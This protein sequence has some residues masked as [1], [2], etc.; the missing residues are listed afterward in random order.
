VKVVQKGFVLKRIV[1]SETSCILSC[2][3][4]EYGLKSF[5]FKGARKKS[6]HLLQALSPIE[7]TFENRN[8]EQLVNMFQV[9]LFYNGHDIQT[10]ALKMSVLFFQCELLK[11]VLIDGQV[12]EVLF[13]FVL[14]EYKWLNENQFHSNYLIFWL[15]KL[16]EIIGFDAK[17]IKPNELML[18]LNDSLFHEIK[19]LNKN[20]TLSYQIANKDKKTLIEAILK[21]YQLKTPNFS[22][23]KTFETY[24]TIWYE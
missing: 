19:M 7:F 9:G 18:G 16:I 4:R 12:D 24:Q 14:E 20:E 6:A 23:I 10:N 21:Y 11:N 2:F 22:S 3:T 17:E 15:F 8:T 13:D 1:Y 5:M